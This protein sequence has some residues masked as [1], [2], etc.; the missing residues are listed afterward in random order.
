[1]FHYVVDDGLIYM[2]M[3]DEETKRR[4]PFAFLEDIR[5]RFKSAYGDRGKTAIAFAMNE[6]FQRVLQRQMVRSCTK[7]TFPPFLLLSF[8][9]F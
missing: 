6:D 8:F 1:M 5:Q 2:C 9:F 3:T 7:S 4:L